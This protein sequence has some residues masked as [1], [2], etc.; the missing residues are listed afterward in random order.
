M[1][2]PS[3]TLLFS[4]LASH[5]KNSLLTWNRFHRDNLSLTQNH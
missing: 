2:Q 1:S 3:G 4:V 5:E